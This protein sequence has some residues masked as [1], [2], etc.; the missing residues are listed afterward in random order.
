[1]LNISTDINKL[2]RE[3]ATNPDLPF[4]RPNPLRGFSIPN[5]RRYSLESG[6]NTGYRH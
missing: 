6:L 1:M 2:T 3:T 5:R 4:V